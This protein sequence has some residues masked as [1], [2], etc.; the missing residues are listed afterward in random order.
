MIDAVRTGFRDAYRDNLLERLL[1]VCC[2]VLAALFLPGP[3]WLQFIPDLALPWL[4]LRS[5]ATDRFADEHDP[6]LGLHRM[7]HLRGRH[8]PFGMLAAVLLSGVFISPAIAAH[9]LVHVAIDSV[10]HEHSTWT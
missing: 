7:L 10:T 8:F 5:I 6:Q 2:H 3:W 9:W 4:W 1:D